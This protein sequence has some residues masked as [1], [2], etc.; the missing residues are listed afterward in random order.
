MAGDTVTSGRKQQSQLDE[1]Q[2]V[3]LLLVAGK[4]QQQVEQMVT[5]GPEMGF[6]RLWTNGLGGL[7]SVH[8]R[9]SSSLTRPESTATLELV[10]VMSSGSEVILFSYSRMFNISSYIRASGN[11]T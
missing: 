9:L 7:Q 5:S 2:L 3:G 6:S 1:K 8:Y 10:A 11:S 4:Y